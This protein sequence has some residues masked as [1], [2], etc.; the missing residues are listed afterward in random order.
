MNYFPSFV[1]NYSFIITNLL[2][3]GGDVG[4]RKEGSAV[5]WLSTRGNHRHTTR[6]PFIFCLMNFLTKSGK[7]GKK[8][9]IQ[10]TLNHQN[11][12]SEQIQFVEYVWHSRSAG[13]LE[14]SWKST[15]RKMSD[16]GGS[17]WQKFASWRWLATPGLNIICNMM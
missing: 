5:I 14:K 7:K 10:Q 15:I 6:A 16:R 11:I 8:N 4:G 17:M 12:V 9:K 3:V 13:V 2:V 1:Y